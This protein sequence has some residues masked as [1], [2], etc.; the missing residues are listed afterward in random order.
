M[1]LGYFP[2]Q[3]LCTFKLL[4]G[5]VLVSHTLQLFPRSMYADNMTSYLHIKP[6]TLKKK[7][8]G[9]SIYSLHLYKN[10]TINYRLYNHI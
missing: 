4:L 5:C 10:K 2:T 6:H 8:T 3:H 1:H 7:N 9:A